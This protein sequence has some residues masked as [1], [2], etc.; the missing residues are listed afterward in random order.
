[1]L[2]ILKKQFL[3][4][5]ALCSVLVLSACREAEQNRPIVKKKGSYEGPT[6]EKL[7]DKTLRELRHRGTKQGF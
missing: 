5:A 1:M 6:D 4:C 3:I 7:K 2:L